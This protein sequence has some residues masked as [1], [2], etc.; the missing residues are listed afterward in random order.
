MSVFHPFLYFS[1]SK[2]KKIEMQYFMTNLTQNV[3]ASPSTASVYYWPRMA[4]CFQLHIV[5]LV[6][7][8]TDGSGV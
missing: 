6:M 7:Q 3:D 5:M 8:V 1:C 4:M 2:E